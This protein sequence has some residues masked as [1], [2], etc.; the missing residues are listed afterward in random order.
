MR[1]KQWKR[2]GGQQ[3]VSEGVRDMRSPMKRELFTRLLDCCQLPFQI[4]INQGRM[5]IL[6]REHSCLWISSA[7]ACK[8]KIRN[9][10]RA[11]Y[12]IKDIQ[13]VL[14][15]RMCLVQEFVVM[16]ECILIAA[17]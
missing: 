9:V 14:W 8:L 5:Y 13:D 2:G 1:P 6:M 11:Y 10:V 3:S 7:T 4:G 17:Y 12:A 15:Y 16:Y